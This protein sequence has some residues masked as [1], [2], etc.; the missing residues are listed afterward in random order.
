MFL[1]VFFWGGEVFFD[2]LIGQWKKYIISQEPDIILK[3]SLE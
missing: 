2:I 3:Q 1:E